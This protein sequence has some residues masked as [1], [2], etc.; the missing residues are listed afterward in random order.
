MYV[1]KCQ[2]LNIKTV[3]V[4]ICKMGTLMCS[5]QGDCVSDSVRTVGVWQVG[6]GFVIAMVNILVE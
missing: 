1:V 2:G 3:A 5:L 4:F 6:H